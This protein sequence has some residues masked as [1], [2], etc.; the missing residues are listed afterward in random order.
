M[1]T[2]TSSLMWR[3]KLLSFWSLL[4][5]KSWI[6]PSAAL[7]TPRPTQLPIGWACSW[8]PAWGLRAEGNGSSTVSCP[9]APPF[10]PPVP[11]WPFSL[12]GF[13]LKLYFKVLSWQLFLF[14]SRALWHLLIA[15]IRTNN[16]TSF[17]LFSY[18]SL[19][20]GTILKKDT[21][22]ETMALLSFLLAS[23]TLPCFH[24]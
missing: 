21:E 4:E 10:L 14:C 5:R 22:K 9:Q 12:V 18:H 19:K 11:Q 20:I 3:S 16:G 15:I 17:I 13:S 24:V 2:L 1:N 6:R 8:Y 7:L 23:I